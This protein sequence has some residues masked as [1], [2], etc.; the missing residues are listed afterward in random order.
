MIKQTQCPSEQIVVKSVK[1]GFINDE[2]AA[3]IQ[4]CND[5]RETIKSFNSFKQIQQRFAAEKFAVSRSRLGK[6]RCEIGKKPP[7]KSQNRFTLLNAS[8]P[9][10]P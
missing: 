10:L 3:H 9:S 5:C 4:S 8:V 2:I 1:S 7:S 6:A